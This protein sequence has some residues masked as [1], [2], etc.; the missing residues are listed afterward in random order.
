MTIYEHKDTVFA[1]AG[2]SASTSLS[3]PGGLL[4]YVF[5]RSNNSSTIFKATLNDSDGTDRISYDFHTNEI[6]DNV[7]VLPLVGKYTVQVTNASLDDTFKI[8]LGV[9]ENR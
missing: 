2:S 3:I 8:I 7:I 6:I 4:R 1:T 5:I 9:Q